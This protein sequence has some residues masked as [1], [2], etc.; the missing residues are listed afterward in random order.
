[1]VLVDGEEAFEL[2]VEAEELRGRLDTVRT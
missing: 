1:V 2:G